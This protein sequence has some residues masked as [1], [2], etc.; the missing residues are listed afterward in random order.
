MSAT[1]ALTEEGT[2][3]TVQAYGT[4]IHYHDIGSGD[5]LVMLHSYGPG[6]TAWVTFHK[7]F[8]EMSEHFRCI[9]MDLPNYAKTGPILYEEPMHK[10]QAKMAAALMDE[11]GIERAHILGNS[12]GGQSALTF[13]YMFKERINKL[14]WGGGHIGTSGGYPNEY[15]M[16]NKPEEGIIASR[17]ASTN[18]TRENFRRYLDMHIIDKSLITD[19]LVDYLIHQHT[20]RQDLV[21]ARA[22]STSLPYDHSRE[23]MD[24]EAPT[25]IIWGRNDRTCHF[26]IGINCLNLVRNSRLVVLK[27]TGHW[28][29][30]EKPAEYNAHVLNFLKGDW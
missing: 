11:L 12:Q 10:V 15:L 23:I 24:I 28:S 17:E 5:P 8:P 26:E 13:A 6:T 2:S 16:V 19:D 9:A 21:E 30:F 29:P 14:I 7:N 18:P 1:A 25:L 27:D 20:G 22:K 4:T 3:K